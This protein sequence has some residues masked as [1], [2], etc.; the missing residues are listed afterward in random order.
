MA[1]NPITDFGAIGD[2]VSDDTSAFVGM[3]AHLNSTGEQCDL[4]YGKY[5]IDAGV[6]DL[7]RSGI[8]MYGRGKGN[9]A[10]LN[11][12]TEAQTTLVIKGMGASI[13]VRDQSIKLQ[14]FRITSDAER[15]TNGFDI[16]SPG[17]RVEPD[18]TTTAR[19]DRCGIY[20]LRIDNQPGDAVLSVGS[21]TYLN[22]ERIDAYECKGFGFR[23]DD[24]SYHGLTR[25]NKHYPG[26]V[27]NVDCRVGFCGGHAIAMSNPSV[28][29]QA[30][31]AIRCKI[32]NLDS[33]GNGQ[34]T[35]IMYS[36]ADGNFYDFW[37]FGEN[38][39]IQRSAACG[40]VG[41]T[42]T[43]ELIGG[44]WIAGR[45]MEINNCRFIDTKQPIYWGNVSAQP[46]SG[47]SID[48]FRI[49]NS[50]LTHTDCVSV[51][52]SAS[53]GLR[54]N[55]DRNDYFTNIATRRI[56][57]VVID[58]KINYQG[59]QLHNSSI[60]GTGETVTVGD[61]ECYVIPIVGTS[62]SLVMQG[63]FI[64]S[65]TSASS[66]GG[67]FHVRMSSSG[68]VSTKWAGEPNTLAHPLGGALNGETGADGKI[69]V[70]C[71][72]TKIYIENR[73]G[74][75]I[76]FTYQICSFSNGVN[77]GEPYVA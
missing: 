28:T 10:N 20:D 5:L 35:S 25:A 73:R 63:V 64:L 13:R 21:V 23:H 42:L 4:G 70:S 24:G 29:Q 34:N 54:I 65:C 27:N 37:I 47:L 38:C 2:G 11:P 9:S 44:V 41:L 76:T 30:G 40:R 15:K 48:M 16:N 68:A 53:R 46:S 8:V 69:N 49:V 51:Q 22:E 18:D 50:N 36:S 12:S 55:Y 77:L 72:N 3:V 1:V 45:D 17:I 60:T 67:V 33:F 56:S 14:D 74:Y 61:D 39:I 6:I 57:G 75:N 58:S 52:S 66:G 26:L 71:D 59:K 32:E 7:S 31:M 19:A 62:S 43:P